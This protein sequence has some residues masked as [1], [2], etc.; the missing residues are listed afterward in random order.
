M[1]GLSLPYCLASPLLGFITDKYP[2]SMKANVDDSFIIACWL[3]STESLVCVGVHQAARSWFM[4]IGSTATAIGFCLL[5]P[6]PF[7]HIPR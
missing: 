3:F 5:G 1:L 4:V 2:V 6:I 7:L